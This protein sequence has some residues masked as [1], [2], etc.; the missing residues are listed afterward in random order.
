M[1]SN[2]FLGGCP[3]LSC[4]TLSG[5]LHHY[6]TLQVSLLANVKWSP[7]PLNCVGYIVAGECLHTSQMVLLLKNWPHPYCVANSA[8]PSAKGLVRTLAALRLSQSTLCF[9][10]EESLC[11]LATQ[12]TAINTHI[13]LCKDLAEGSLASSHFTLPSSHIYWCYKLNQ[14]CYKATC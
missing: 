10:M 7:Q 9:Y 4:G 5:R 11:Q 6:K 3:D 1:I 8:K 2:H 12:C 14:C 13:K